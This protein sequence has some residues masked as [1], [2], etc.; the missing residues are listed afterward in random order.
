MKSKRISNYITCGCALSLMNTM[1]D[2][3]PYWIYSW[4]TTSCGIG[5]AQSNM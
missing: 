1:K 4:K 5:E 3:Y 2:V